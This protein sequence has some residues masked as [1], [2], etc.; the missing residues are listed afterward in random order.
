MTDVSDRS[1][2]PGG[3]SLLRTLVIAAQNPG[4]DAQWHSLWEHNLSGTAL[5]AGF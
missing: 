1:G 5:A 2:E 4:A 3:V